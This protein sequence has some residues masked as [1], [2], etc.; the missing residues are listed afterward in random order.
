MS[1]KHS[2]SRQQ[3]M[4]A[5]VFVAAV[6]HDDI[7]GG[8]RAVHDFSHMTADSS[9]TVQLAGSLAVELPCGPVRDGT[10]T[11]GP[12]TAAKAAPE[13]MPKTATATAMA[14]SKL[15]LAAVKLIVAV[16]E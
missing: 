6:D 4:L 2:A 7:L 10:S 3:A 13:L 15:L 16:L 1:E 5:A 9:E 8:F 11:S 12:M 14:S